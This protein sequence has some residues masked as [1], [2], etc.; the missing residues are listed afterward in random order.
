MLSQR[1]LR[2]ELNRVTLHY[3]PLQ[4]R[5]NLPLLVYRTPVILANKRV[6]AKALRLNG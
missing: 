5:G 1:R 4:K 3:K 2:V 6:S